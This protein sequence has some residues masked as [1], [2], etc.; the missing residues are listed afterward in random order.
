MSTFSYYFMRFPGG[1]GKALTLSYDDGVE[2]DIRLIQL[3]EQYGF[4]GT[5]N[6]NSGLFAPEDKVY[7]CGKIHRR[8]SLSKIK[9]VFSSPNVEVACHGFEH[10]RI[11]RLHGVD[12]MSEIIADRR[13]LE[14]L[15][16]RM[17]PGM[18]Y[19]YG[20][21]ND[22]AVEVLKLAGIRY[23]RTVES[24]ECF[25]IPTDWLRM[26]ATCHHK[27]PRL[28]ELAEKFRHLEI[29]SFPKLFYLWGHSYEFEGDDNWNVIEDFFKEMQNLPDVWYATNIEICDYVRAYERLLFSAGN[30]IVHNPNAIDVWIGDQ[31]GKIF[32][33]PAGKTVDLI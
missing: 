12:A 10:L 15:F 25:D 29:T 22:Q 7:P 17:I 8:L 18:A 2:Q 33:I 6:L 5:F 21:Y 3:M 27:N 13:E 30:R 24:T 9:E 26:P 32:C 16:D 31:D 1:K 4:K 28:M 23:A 11:E 14:A 19:A 20:T